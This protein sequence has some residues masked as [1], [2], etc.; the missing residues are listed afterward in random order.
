M[1]PHQHTSSLLDVSAR[2]NGIEHAATQ[3]VSSRDS[4]LGDASPQTV[5]DP[6][7]P[8]RA[9]NKC[10]TRDSDETTVDC[11]VVADGAP[12]DETYVESV[13]MNHLTVGV[14]E[15][16]DLVSNM[17]IESAQEYTSC[18]VTSV[19]EYRLPAATSSENR[20]FKPPSFSTPYHYEFQHCSNFKNDPPSPCHE[21]PS[22]HLPNTTLKSVAPLQQPAS[23]AA[24]SGPSMFNLQVT[25]SE[26][27]ESILARETPEHL[28]MTPEIKIIDNSFL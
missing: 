23:I 18:A 10:L 12:V 8:W 24:S 14:V 28:W 22:D 11:S 21:D 2:G 9:E 17:S 1:N 20:T 4:V 16:S 15:L 27:E 6:D 7:V 19:L 25:E 26:D 3:A 13:D 5:P